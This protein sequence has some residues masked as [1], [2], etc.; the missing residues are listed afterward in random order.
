EA[1][2]LAVEL[3]KKLSRKVEIPDG[4][5]VLG[6]ADQDIELWIDKAMNDVCLGGN[7]VTPSSDEIRSLYREAL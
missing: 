2:Q 1:A 7:P 4:F 6:V 5:R 3:I